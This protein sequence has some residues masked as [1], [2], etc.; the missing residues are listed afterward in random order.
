M[1]RPVDVACTIEISGASGEGVG[2]RRG[3]HLYGLPEEALAAFVAP[4]LVLLALGHVTAL[5]HA[6]RG[7]GVLPYNGH[8]WGLESSWENC[9]HPVSAKALLPCMPD[10]EMSCMQAAWLL[11]TLPATALCLLVC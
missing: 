6:R 4:L 1:C 11:V 7:S 3:L 2:C 5:V 8:A 10:V 9:T